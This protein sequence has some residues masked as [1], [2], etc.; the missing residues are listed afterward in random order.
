MVKKLLYVA[1]LALSLATTSCTLDEGPADSLP[2]GNYVL[3]NIK[4]AGLV[5]FL[6]Y[7]YDSQNRIVTCSMG[8]DETY[9]MTYKGNSTVPSQIVI[10]SYDYYSPELYG[11]EEERFLSDES[12]CTVTDSSNGRITACSFVEKEWAIVYK[13]KVVNGEIRGY[14]EIEL[15]EQDFYTQKLEYDAQGHCTYTADSDGDW[16]RINW[17]NGLLTDIRHDDG[18]YLTIE[19]CDVE[20]P[21]GQ[22]DPLL[23]C[24]GP[25][26]IAGWFGKAPER[27]VKS[28]YYHTVEDDFDEHVE[29]SYRLLSNGLIQAARYNGYDDG[30]MTFTYNYKAI[31]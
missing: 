29:I 20:N 31:R 9:E 21:V 12:V 15:K 17:K 6:N 22:W 28:Y 2:E 16:S 30:L 26:Q 8:S 27:F 23:P 1:C 11:D 24:F 3:A 7:E 14:N 4:A 25:I 13:E 5:P 19:Y 10:R 18:D